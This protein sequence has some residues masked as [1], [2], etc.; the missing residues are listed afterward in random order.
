MTER[1]TPVRRRK[2]RTGPPVID[3]Q[4]GLRQTTLDA[5]D[6]VSMAGGLSRSLYLELLLQQIIRANE[7]QLPRLDYA[8]EG[9]EELRMTG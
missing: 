9:V 4:V 6:E 5:V 2:R 7:G 1:S 3:V 8:L